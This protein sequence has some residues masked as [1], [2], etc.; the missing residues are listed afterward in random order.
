MPGIRSTLY[1]AEIDADKIQKI[2]GDS[3]LFDLTPDLDLFAP[4]PERHAAD[5]I[6][7]T[8]RTID[9]LVEIL[10]EIRTAYQSELDARSGSHVEAW[11]DG[12]RPRP[13]RDPFMPMRG[14]FIPDRHVGEEL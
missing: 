3:F 12:T 10:S 8:I 6:A 5:K 7:Q 4:T 2:G 14:G 1:L 11:L 9:R 13:K